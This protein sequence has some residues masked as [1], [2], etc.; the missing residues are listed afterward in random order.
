MSD[1][2]FLKA[3]HGGL[4]DNLQFSTLPE[5]FFK[6]KNKKTYIVRAASFRNKEIFDLVWGCNP[7]VVGLGD[8]EWNAGDLPNLT[9]SNV[10]NN[11]IKNWES[12]HGLE[13]KNKYP[14]IYYR[15]K[16]LLDLSN[17]ILV[18]LSSITISYDFENL[19]KT[20]LK[21]KNEYK[22]KMFF[23]VL[24]KNNILSK[25]HNLYEFECENTIMINN[26]FDYCDFI[27][28]AFGFVGLNSGASHLTSAIKQEHG[29]LK[30]ICII[31]EDWYN[32]Q[33]QK[34]IFL[35]DN[36]EYVTC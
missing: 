21:I 36:V 12:L 17:V 15:P 10:C 14:K 22:D 27:N 4:G 29:D 2:I 35:F 8:G 19:K 9:Y 30:S 1:H 18:D 34:G 28:S 11:P 24:F 23:R 32:M 7:F 20:Y 16:K 33:K 5:E 6:Q 31:P 25:N 3:F 26:I 13:P